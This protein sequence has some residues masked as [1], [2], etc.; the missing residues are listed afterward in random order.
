M[1]ITTAQLAPWVKPTEAELDEHPL[2]QSILWQATVLINDAAQQDWSIED[3]DKRPPEI[4]QSIAIQLCAR[5]FN[6][7]K[8]L[9][10]RSTGPMN[11]R[12]ANEV[13]TG[14][15]L[16]PH[17]IESLMALRPS[18]KGG[19]WVQPLLPFTEL[20]KHYPPYQDADGT[21]YGTGGEPWSYDYA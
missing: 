11:E 1:L 21:S 18:G 7:P 20:D 13:L 6:N 2:A 14:M 12:Y 10:M 3:D 9:Q 5:V 15:A 4:A 17:E 16:R 19:L 8:V